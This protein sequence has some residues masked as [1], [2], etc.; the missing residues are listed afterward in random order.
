MA[1]DSLL[2][3]LLKRMLKGC[4][5]HVQM[6]SDHFLRLILCLRTCSNGC[7]NDAQTMFKCFLTFYGNWFFAFELAETRG[8]IILKGWVSLLAGPTLQNFSPAVAPKSHLKPPLFLL[9]LLFFFLCLFL[10]LFSC[11]PVFLISSFPSFLFSRFPVLPFSRFPVFLFS[12]FPDFPFSC[13]PVFPFPCFPDFLVSRFCGFPCACNSFLASLACLPITFCPLP[14]AWQLQ[15]TSLSLCHALCSCSPSLLLSLSPGPL[16]PTARCTY[17][18][19]CKQTNLR[20]LSL[21]PVPQ[22][23]KLNSPTADIYIISYTWYIFIY[24]I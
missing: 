16:F 7:S 20:Q 6:S 8:F 22:K 23:I 15:S 19:K 9:P 3:K 24:N 5:N 10:F 11:F 14:V 2:A 1:I 18:E 4:S 17:T 13:F 12:W 21:T